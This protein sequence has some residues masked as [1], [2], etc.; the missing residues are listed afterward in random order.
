MNRRST[1][2]VAVA[3]ILARRRGGRLAPVARTAAHRHFH[4]TGLLQE[5]PAGGPKLLWRV[6]NVGSGFSTPS[7]VGAAHVSP[8]QRGCGQR[9]RARAERQ[10]RQ[11]G[12]VD[13]YR[14][15]R[16]RRSAAVV[17]GDAIDADRRRRRA[18]RAGVGW[19]PGRPRSGHGPGA[20]E[21]EPSDRLR[22]RAGNLGIF[23]I[24]AARRRRARGHARRTD[25][26]RRPEQEDRAR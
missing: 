15:G 17:S 25:V 20:L 13:A 5:W 10:R 22:R 11:A 2:L 24:A 12:L 21:E 3:V 18:L 7:V 9:V 19:R 4:E 16:Q 1:F 26:A 8:E 6:N 14:Q 23:G